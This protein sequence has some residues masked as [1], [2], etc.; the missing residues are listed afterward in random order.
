MKS[1]K[2]KIKPWT[3]N[4]SIT[5]HFKPGLLQT[6]SIST[7]GENETAACSLHKCVNWNLTSENKDHIDIM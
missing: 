4:K 7:S 2:K 3:L 6:E 1:V 5:T